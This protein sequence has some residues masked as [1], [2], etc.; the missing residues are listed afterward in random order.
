MTGLL[1]TVKS[2][3]TAVETLR[4]AVA[5]GRVHHAYL[6]DGPDGVGKERTAFGLAQALVCE[7]RQQGASEACGECRACARAVP[8]PGESR[9][10]HPDVIVLER[11]LYDP[12]VIGRKSPETQEISIDQVR[13]L[14][15]A[16]SAF[17]PHEGRAKV[18]I[19]RRAEEL[20]ISAANALLKTLEE[21]GARTHFV[22]LSA[23]AD[24]LLPTIRS[25][26]QRVRFGALPDAV[27]AELLVARG[28]ERTLAD[29]TARLS[30]GSMATAI[31][32]GDPDASARREEFVSRALAALY[33]R[34]LGGALELA[35]EGKKGDKGTLVVQIEAL[36][37]ALA[38]RARE[39]AGE[40]DRRAD[41]AAT[42][43]SLALAAIQQLDGNAS[44]QLTVEA[45]LMKMRNA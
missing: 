25:R 41:S 18:F 31:T 4:R 20:S 26:T 11:G 33:A 6:F 7:R 8:R 40:A 39:S 9:P 2:Q 43:H 35:E 36:A 17:A 5:T 44:S 16:R 1:S 15:L 14:V 34:D 37:A 29:E 42:R 12:A 38:T 24:A 32:L 27:V 10:L 23:S 30:G 13:T 45:M 21:P 3:P 19:V 28:V 22:L